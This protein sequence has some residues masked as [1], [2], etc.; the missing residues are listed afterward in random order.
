[1]EMT[2]IN[3]HYFKSILEEQPF[4]EFLLTKKMPSMKQKKLFSTNLCVQQG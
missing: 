2:G 1:M 3:Y 4:K